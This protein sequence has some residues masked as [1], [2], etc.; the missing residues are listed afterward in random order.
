MEATCSH[1]TLVLVD[2]TTWCHMPEDNYHMSPVFKFHTPVTI[3]VLAQS[4]VQAEARQRHSELRNEVT[5][6]PTVLAEG[7]MQGKARQ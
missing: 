1:N 5:I 2:Q 7:N 4:K 6:R 3:T